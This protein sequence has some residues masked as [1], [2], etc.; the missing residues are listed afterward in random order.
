MGIAKF[1]NFFKENFEKFARNLSSTFRIICVTLV[2]ETKIWTIIFI[3]R[4][5]W[6]F[7]VKFVEIFGQTCQN[8]REFLRKI[9]RNFWKI[10]R[11][12]WV[13]FTYNYSWNFP[14]KYYKNFGVEICDNFK[15]HVENISGYGNIVKNLRKFK[16]LWKAFR[17]IGSKYRINFCT[18][19]KIFNN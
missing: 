9:W 5:S 8:F 2:K 12:C 11:K 10:R 7:L 13:N 15:E 6:V 1:K 19:C 18:I 4:K 3:N 16:T 14:V 17:K